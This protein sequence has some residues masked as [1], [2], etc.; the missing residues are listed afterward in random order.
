MA[1][2]IDINTTW[3]KQDDRTNKK[4]AGILTINVEFGP[5]HATEFGIRNEFVEALSAIVLVDD[6]F[7]GAH[8]YTVK[9]GKPDARLV[10]HTKHRVF[11][12]RPKEI[13]SRE[14]MI[15]SLGGR[16]SVE[17]RFARYAEMAEEFIKVQKQEREELRQT[18]VIVRHYA[19]VA[20]DQAKLNVRY[21]QR[22]AALRAE[23]EAEVEAVIEQR[24]ESWK[25]ETLAKDDVIEESVN[26][27]FEVLPAFASKEA[28]KEG[29]FRTSRPDPVE[30]D[31]ITIDEW[32]KEKKD[33]EVSES[34]AGTDA[35]E[36]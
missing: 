22:M 24:H 25:E 27:A 35:H 28:K 14:E 1:N 16:A 31:I 5:E 9:Q 36:G 6:L 33:A 20:R 3:E 29:H 7:S 26:E 30:R 34:V 21:K 23:Y 2:I 12:E 4:Y 8:H 10:F 11:V 15:A 13:P 32:L 17:G 18:N 19:S